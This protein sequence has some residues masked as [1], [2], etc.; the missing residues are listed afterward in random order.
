ML[1]IMVSTTFSK[2]FDIYEK[3]PI[4]L[5]VLLF[6]IPFGLLTFKF[7]DEVII[8]STSFTGAYLVVRP[9][10]WFFGGYPN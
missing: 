4:I 9:F 5:F 10:S 6:S 7:H 8:A 3:W 2:L 1:G